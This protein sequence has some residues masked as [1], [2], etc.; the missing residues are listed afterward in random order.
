MLKKAIYKILSI[1]PLDED[2][3]SDS[4]T[5]A[6]NSGLHEK[7]L[8]QIQ[9]S[10]FSVNDEEPESTEGFL[11]YLQVDNNALDPRDVG[12]INIDTNTILVSL[13]DDG[14]KY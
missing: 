4:E 12:R 10:Q 8:R 7:S 3:I 14:G 11:L 6:F 1:H 13:R 9:G 5:L 2:I